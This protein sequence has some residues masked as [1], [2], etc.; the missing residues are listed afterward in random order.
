MCENFSK[1]RTCPSQAKNIPTWQKSALGVFQFLQSILN[2]KHTVNSRYN[3]HGYIEIPV[4]TKSVKFP[5]L[6]NE[7]DHN[8]VRLY[9]NGYIE[10]P[11][12][13]K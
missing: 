3:E 9:R 1:T 12:I 11:L 10:I 2:Y 4:I 7:L 5:K 13:S 8:K 6:P